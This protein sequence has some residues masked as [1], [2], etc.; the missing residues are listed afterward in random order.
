MLK[1]SQR[2]ACERDRAKRTD[3]L[4]NPRIAVGCSRTAEESAVVGCSK[5]LDHS[6]EEAS[7]FDRSK[8]EGRRTTEEGKETRRNLGRVVLEVERRRLE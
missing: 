8:D 1:V 5:E 4:T 7:V 6:Y 3:E 2:T